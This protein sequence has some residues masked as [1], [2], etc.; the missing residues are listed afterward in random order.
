MIVIV[1]SG[2]GYE[3][4]VQHG[5]NARERIATQ[6]PKW[7]RD[8]EQTGLGAAKDVIAEFMATTDFLSGLTSHAPH[9]LEEIRG[10]AD[11]AEFPF[12]EVFAFNCMDEL[13]CFI[14]RQKAPGPMDAFRGCSV[15]GVR[16]PS[17]G[18]KILGQNMDLGLS[19]VGGADV[20][21]IEPT[22]V[23]AGQLVVT[24]VG[25]IGLAG[26]NHYGV[27]VCV[28]TLMGLAHQQSGVPVAAVTRLILEQ[29]SLAAGAECVTSLPHASG[30]AYTIGSP[31]G[32]RCF[33]ACAGGVVEWPGDRDVV[34]HTNHALVSGEVNKGYVK[35]AT[36]E[37]ST[38]KRLAHLVEH[39][40]RNRSEC[41][42][43]LRNDSVPMWFTE[44]NSA[45]TAVTF[46]SYIYELTL[47]PVMYLR[48]GE[49]VEVLRVPTPR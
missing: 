2:T 40:P 26:V 14:D 9:L 18:P 13:W 5:I 35:T 21:A 44:E 45:G 22:A 6:W 15:I 48:V 46:A 24:H 27:G 49:T 39:R 23:V 41:D 31:D 33:E 12:D 29:P 4:G 38:I 28:N 30:Q 34:L 19:T 36:G 11:G 8:L 43:V 32:I 20:L 25:M 37:S 17:S 10:I 3:R 1:V 47:E 7:H 42:A 16:H